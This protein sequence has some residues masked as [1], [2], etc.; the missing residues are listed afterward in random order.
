MGDAL[1]LTVIATGFDRHA[2]AEDELEQ[3]GS[4]RT[5]AAPRRSSPAARAVA[6]ARR[7]SQVQV[8]R[9]ARVEPPALNT[10][11]PSEIP[12]FLRRRDEGGF[13]R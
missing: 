2:P 5:P 7:Q 9:P 10:S 12:A 4:A 13:I 3:V 8:T 6:R 1:R 11:D